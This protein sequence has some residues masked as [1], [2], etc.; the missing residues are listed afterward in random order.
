[1]LGFFFRVDNVDFPVKVK[2]IEPFQVNFSQKKSHKLEITRSITDKGKIYIPSIFWAVLDFLSAGEADLVLVHSS[3]CVSKNLN[4][5][6]LHQIEKG[7]WK[8][9]KAKKKK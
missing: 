6:A 3:M 8:K 1:M 9:E 7:V 4:S 5:Q 2:K